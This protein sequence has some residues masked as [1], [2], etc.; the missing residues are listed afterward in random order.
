MDSIAKLIR[1]Q[2]I[3][4]L[5]ELSVLQKKSHYTFSLFQLTY[6]EAISF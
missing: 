6:D 1:D 2:I 4:L 5:A 3:K